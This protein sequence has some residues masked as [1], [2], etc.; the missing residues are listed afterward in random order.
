MVTRSR[1]KVTPA[2]LVQLDGQVDTPASCSH[3]RA[4]TSDYTPSPTFLREPNWGF[5]NKLEPEPEHETEPK[6]E[7][8]ETHPEHNL[9]HLEPEALPD[10]GLQLNPQPEPEPELLPDPIADNE[11]Q[12]CAYCNEFW[13][14]LQDPAGINI[15]YFKCRNN[16]YNCCFGLKFCTLYCHQTWRSGFQCNPSYFR[17]KHN[18]AKSDYCI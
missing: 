18:L 7:T 2:M 10:P 15:P 1:G 5:S 12:N 16:R 6:P 11:K 13:N 4:K 8:L 9:E 14:R 17:K 3:S